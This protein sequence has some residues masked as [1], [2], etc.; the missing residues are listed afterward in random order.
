MKAMVIF[1]L[2]AIIGAAVANAD[3]RARTVT[4]QEVVL[5]A[6]RTWHYL[7]ESQTRR[8]INLAGIDSVPLGL[9]FVAEVAPWLLD[10][11]IVHDVIRLDLLSATGD[12]PDLV[13]YR[14]PA[15]AGEAEQTVIRLRVGE[16]SGSTLSAVH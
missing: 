5:R 4:G 9:H 8:R 15:P 10:E 13:L 16:R 1:A 11:S 3:I 7:H 14:A 6:D 2:V 12:I